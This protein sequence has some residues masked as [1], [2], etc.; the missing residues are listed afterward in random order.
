MEPAEVPVMRT[1]LRGDIMAGGWY[2]RKGQRSHVERTFGSVLGGLA[3][4]EVLPAQWKAYNAD[5]MKTT[6]PIFLSI[7]SMGSA[8]LRV[9]FLEGKGHW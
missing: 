1:D 8:A 5:A 6:G 4:G 9:R 7:E 2:D 3:S